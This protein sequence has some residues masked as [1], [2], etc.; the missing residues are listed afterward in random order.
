MKIIDV[1]QSGKCGVKVSQGGRYG[2][3]VRALV[4][5]TNPRTPPQMGVRRSLATTSI[6][7]RGLTPTQRNSWTSV[8]KTRN[9]KPKLGQS[10]ALTGCQLYTQV[11]ATLNL[12]S[13]QNVTEPPAIPAIPPLVLTGVHITNALGV[14][15]IYF[16]CPDDP[17]EYTLI[18]ASAPMSQGRNTCSSFRLLGTCPAPLQN[19]ADV[20]ALYVAKFGT[21]AAGTKIFFSVNQMVAGFEDIPVEWSAIVPA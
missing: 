6:A 14:L 4:I 12:V 13:A 10:G 8:A 15:A 21:P 1:P 5:P 2:Q 19:K 11:N 20:T 18:R 16:D 9:S 17:T 7:W 3:V